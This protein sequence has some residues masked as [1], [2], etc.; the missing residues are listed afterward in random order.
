MMSDAFERMVKAVNAVRN[1]T[2]ETLSGNRSG[3]IYQVNAGKVSKARAEAV[4]SGAHYQIKPSSVT[5]NG[6][7]RRTYTAS[8]PGEAPAVL[9]GRLRQ[10]IKGTVDIEGKTIVGRVGTD[11]PYGPMLEYGTRNMAARP[12]L[13]LSFEKSEPEIREALGL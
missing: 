2:L 13:R 11:V 8:D 3:E 9:T 7:T 6:T 10:S 1:T 12:W 5:I 4:R